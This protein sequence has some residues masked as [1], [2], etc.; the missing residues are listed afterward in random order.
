MKQEKK[1]T[2]AQMQRRI[3][4]AVL[5][6][7][8]TKDTIS[9]YFSDKGLRLTVDDNEGYCII[10]TVF[11]RHVFANHTLAGISRPYTYTKRVVEIA[12]ELEDKIAAKDGYSF[13]RLLSVLKEDKESQSKYLIVFYFDMWAAA[14]FSNLYD[15][16]ETDAGS[17]I[18]YLDYISHLSKHMILL[19]EKMEDMSNKQFIAKYIDNIKNL[20]EDIQE[21]ILFPKKTD[22]ELVQ[23]EVDAA[24]ANEQEQI[25]EEQADGE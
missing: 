23:E 17:F 24:N 3:E 5:H 16:S 21:V 2:N 4:K 13:Q 14:I 1:Q 9:I 15:I 18:V 11:H 22:E 6:L 19:S 8:R 10:E 12:M 25:M 7:Y 20:T